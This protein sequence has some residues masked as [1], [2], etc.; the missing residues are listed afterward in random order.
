MDIRIY[1]LLPLGDQSTLVMFVLLEPMVPEDLEQL[2]QKIKDQLEDSITQKVIRQLLSL[3][4]VLPLLVPAQRKVVSIPWGRTQ[5]RV[6]QRNVG[7]MSMR[8][9]PAWLPLEKFMRGWRP[10]TTS[11][12][13]MIKWSSVLRKFEKLML[14]FRTHSRGLVSGANT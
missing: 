5:T 9:L 4:L 11:L 1:W 10:S 3:R 12:W 6:T 14:V 13:T 8:I 2:K 7:C